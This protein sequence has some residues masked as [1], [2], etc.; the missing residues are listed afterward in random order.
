MGT[1]EKPTD[2]LGPRIGERV[3]SGFMHDGYAYIV[4]AYYIDFK[5]E[6]GIKDRFEVVRRTIDDATAMTEYVAVDL[7]SH[8]IVQFLCPLAH[9]MDI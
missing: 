3:I 8:E 7:D 6:F 4:R 5:N 1:G 2:I 9:N